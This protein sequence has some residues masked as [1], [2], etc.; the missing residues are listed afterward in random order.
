MDVQDLTLLAALR[1]PQI[2][3]LGVPFED[4]ESNSIWG[5]HIAANPK[6]SGLKLLHM[7]DWEPRVDPVPILRSLPVLTELIVGN[8]QVLDVTFFRAFIPVG[9]NRA[10][11]LKQSSDEGDMPLMLCPMLKSLLIEEVDPRAKP[12]LLVLEEVVT[13]RAVCGS[14]LKTFRFSQ[15]EPKLQKEFELIDKMGSFAWYGNSYLIEDARPFRL[16]I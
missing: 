10:S 15:F 2:R 6:L 11:I 12:W 9:E 3:E 16:V 1:L 5:K 14:P 7:Q 4:P 8:G 13:L